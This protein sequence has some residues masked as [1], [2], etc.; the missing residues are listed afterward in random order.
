MAAYSTDCFQ[1]QGLQP[2][3]LE[4]TYLSNSFQTQSL[5]Q[6]ELSAASATDELE[7]TALTLSSLQQKEL[8]WLKA[9]KPASSTRASDA[10]RYA[11]ASSMELPRISLMQ[12][13]A[14]RE[15]WQISFRIVKAELP[16]LAS[17]HLHLGG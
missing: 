13:Q 1:Q 8:E 2:D 7:R 12:C 4:A 17:F 6:K 10:E 11:L 15:L 14:R 9:T 3:E 16:T 5:Q